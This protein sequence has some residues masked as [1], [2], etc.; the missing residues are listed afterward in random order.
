MTIKDQQTF[1]DALSAFPSGVTIVS[2][3]DENGHHWGFTASSFSSVSMAPPLVLVC[4]ANKGDSHPAFLAATRYSINILAQDQQAIAMRFARKGVDKFGSHE[5]HYGTE[6]D[7]PAPI[8]PGSMA[9]LV[10][11]ARD[12]V[13]APLI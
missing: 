11:T 4:I 2:T 6:D 1:R 3:T 10:C 7:P 12:D 9:S 13:Q 8:L 5:F